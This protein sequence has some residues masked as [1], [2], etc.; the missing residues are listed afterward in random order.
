MKDIFSEMSFPVPTQ[1]PRKKDVIGK[2]RLWALIIFF[3]GTAVG[4][5][6]IVLFARFRPAFEEWI[7]LDPALFLARAR[8]ILV[9]VAILCVGPLM[10]FIIFLWRLGSRTLQTQCFPPPGTLE[11]RSTPVLS[12]TV[13]RQRG[14]LVQGA[15]VLLFA[16]QVALTMVFWWLLRLGA[17]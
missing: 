3:I 16:A 17:R 7:C 4:T 1:S 15:A 10:A 8:F 12:G 2:Y 13:A 11:V 14:H 5:A 9:G 6:L